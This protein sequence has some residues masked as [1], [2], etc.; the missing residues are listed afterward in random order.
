[1]E[2][3]NLE[4]IIIDNEEGLQDHGEEASA[5]SYSENKA[6]E[7]ENEEENSDQSSESSES[8]VEDVSQVVPRTF[9]SKS[10]LEAEGGLKENRF[11][12]Y[13][14]ENIYALQCAN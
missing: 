7:E 3:E 2:A 4:I 12:T 14:Q 1:M 6:L 8:S 10:Y 13:S 9:I 5:K 11:S